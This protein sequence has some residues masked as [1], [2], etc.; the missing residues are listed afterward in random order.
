MLKQTITV[1]VAF[2]PEVL[3]QPER[4]TV[5]VVDILRASTTLVTM[6]DRG[7]GEVFLAATVEEA[8]ALHRELGQP[9]LLCGEAGGLPPEDF[10]FGNSPRDMAALDLAGKCVVFCSSN[11]AKALSRV[12]ASPRVLVGCY[13]NASAVVATALAD[14][15]RHGRDLAIVCSGRADGTS[16]ATDDTACAGFL[17]DTLLAQVPA[18]ERSWCSFTDPHQHA[19]W[20]YLDDSALVARRLYRSYGGDMETMVR[21]TRDAHKL[22]RLGVGPD[23]PLALR[24]DVSRAVP[25]L[26]MV[27]G[28]LKVTC[29]GRGPLV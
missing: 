26:T 12:S 23:L 10:D 19:D 21:E 6:F 11:G 1:E 28:R 25:E 7:V 27:D 22:M 2:L 13:A 15:R 3:R 9:A 14:A 17:V 4:K 16:F 20:C 24:V 29:A 18:E 5:V 8:R